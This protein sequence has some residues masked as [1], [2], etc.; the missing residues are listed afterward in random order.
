MRREGG[1]EMAPAG[2]FVSGGVFVHAAFLGHALRWANSLSAVFPGCS[3]DCCLYSVCLWAICS[4]VS[5]RAAPMLW[6]LPEPSLLTL[7]L[8]AFSPTGCKNSWNLAPITFQFNCYGDSFSLCTSLWPWSLST[9]AATIH[10]SPKPVIHISSH[11]WY[12]LFCT[13]SCG[14][15]SSSLQVNFWDI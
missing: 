15:C 2:S 3:L 10:F 7:E 12:G 4:A 13:F 5:P 14:V 11:L 9:V 8:H 6:A 1:N